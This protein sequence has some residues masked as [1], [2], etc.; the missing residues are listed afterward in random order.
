[1]SKSTVAAVTSRALC[2]L[3]NPI[4]R[5]QLHSH[6]AGDVSTLGI[7]LS[8]RCPPKTSVTLLFPGS[9]AEKKQRFHGKGQI[10]AI[11]TLDKTVAEQKDKQ[12]RAPWLREGSDVPPVARQRS[13]GAMIKGIW[14]CL[15][16]LEH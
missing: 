11:G 15:W 9:S 4:P 1:M 12:A 10:R 2:I 8:A 7:S 3:K 5:K 6:C 13:A 14:L 16:L